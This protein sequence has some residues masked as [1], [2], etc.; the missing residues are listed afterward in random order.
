MVDF[1]KEYIRM[2]PLYSDWLFLFVRD[3]L[4]TITFV[5]FVLAIVFIKY[6]GELDK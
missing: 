1:F 6:T 2:N 3:W 5:L 4:P